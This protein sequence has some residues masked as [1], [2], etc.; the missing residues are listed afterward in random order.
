MTPDEVN[1]LT[2][3]LYARFKNIPDIDRTFI[4]KC[5][6]AIAGLNDSE[7]DVKIKQLARFL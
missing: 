2:D 1:Y 3:K 5:V 6:Q 7:V 4:F